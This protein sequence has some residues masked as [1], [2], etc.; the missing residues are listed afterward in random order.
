[1][2]RVK[3]RSTEMVRGSVKFRGCAQRGL[4]ARLVRVWQRDLLMTCCSAIHPTAMSDDEPQ[5][6]AWTNRWRLKVREI[7]HE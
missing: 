1:M 7:L 6:T 2:K 5:R 3:A 4:V